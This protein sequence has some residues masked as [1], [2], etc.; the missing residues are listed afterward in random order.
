MKPLDLLSSDLPIHLTPYAMK[1]L[2]FARIQ[3]APPE[4]APEHPHD[5]ARMFGIE[6]PDVHERPLHMIKHLF[7]I[8]C[9]SEFGRTFF[10]GQRGLEEFVTENDHRMREVE[11]WKC[12]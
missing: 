10:D 3:L 6:K 9:F 11:G 5:R 4:E 2:D 7:Q 8:L 1:N 12:S